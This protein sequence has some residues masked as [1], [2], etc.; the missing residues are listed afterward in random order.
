MP[1]LPDIVV[2]LDG[3]LKLLQSMDVSKAA[4]PDQISNG[5]LKLAADEIAP[6]LA[7]IFQQS[8]DTS[9]LPAD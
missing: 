2:S 9:E 7:H 5:T 4:G 3:V 8:L 6:I 1:H